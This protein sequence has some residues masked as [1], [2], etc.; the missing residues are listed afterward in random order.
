MAA[1][2][3][4]ESDSPAVAGYCSYGSGLHR[5]WEFAA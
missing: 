2:G 3:P 5:M 4:G 1:A